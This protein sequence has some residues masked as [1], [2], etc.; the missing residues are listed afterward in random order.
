MSLKERKSTFFKVMQKRSN[1]ARI[2]R[3]IYPIPRP[4]FIHLYDKQNTPR[5][6]ADPAVLGAGKSAKWSTRNIERK[7]WDKARRKPGGR[8]GWYHCVLRGG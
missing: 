6:D 5:R 8:T 3:H 1:R 7:G 4:V 2:G